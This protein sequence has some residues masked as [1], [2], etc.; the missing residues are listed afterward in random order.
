MLDSVNSQ[1][2]YYILRTIILRESQVKLSLFRVHNFK[3]IFLAV[4]AAQEMALSIS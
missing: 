1:D 2:K 3:L 4:S